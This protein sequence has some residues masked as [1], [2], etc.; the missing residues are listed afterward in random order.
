MMKARLYVASVTLSVL[1][2]VS[3]SVSQEMVSQHQHHNEQDAKKDAAN[4]ASHA[5]EDHL[6]GVNSRGDHA[7]GFSHSRATHHFRL[8]ATGGTIEVSAND[9]NDTESRDQIR[10]HLEHISKLFAAGDFTKPMFTH[11]RVPPGTPVMTRLKS[12]IAYS[13]EGTERGGRVR[14]STKNADALAAIH[15]FL[16]FQ[17]KDHETGDSLEVDSEK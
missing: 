9:A 14:I 12:E 7:M 2:L 4:K 10:N 3:I 16:R 6:G 8:T 5:H 17:I 11:N 1:A 15:D 13:Y